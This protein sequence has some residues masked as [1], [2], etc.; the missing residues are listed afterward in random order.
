MN[1]PDLDM[2]DIAQ[3]LRTLREELEAQSKGSEGARSTVELDQTT[4]GRLSRMD[5]LQGQAMANAEE[6]RRRLMMRRIAAALMRI[7]SGEYGACIECDEWIEARRLAFDPT[8]L[9][10][11]GCAR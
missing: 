2:Q 9:K 11:I 5:A 8:V 6:E 7:D 4:V 10:C 3:Q 1:H